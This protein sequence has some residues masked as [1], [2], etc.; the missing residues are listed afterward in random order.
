MA[1][2]KKYFNLPL[3]GTYK[4]VVQKMSFPQ[5]FRTPN[6][7]HPGDAPGDNCPLPPAPHYAN[8]TESS[9]LRNFKLDFQNILVQRANR[10]NHMQKFLT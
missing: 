7:D 10:Y 4:R 8:P 6:F 1:K 9:E 2:I 5:K 3:Y